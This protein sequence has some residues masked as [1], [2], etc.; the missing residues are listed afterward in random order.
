MQRPNAPIA[1]AMLVLRIDG[2]TDGT[3]LHC[4]RMLQRFA[5]PLGDCLKHCLAVPVLANGLALGRAE[6][7]TKIAMRPH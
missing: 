1:S 6:S 7:P 2:E 5:L 4:S 3:L